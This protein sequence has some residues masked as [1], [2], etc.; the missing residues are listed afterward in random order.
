MAK[1][2][3]TIIHVN[4]IVIRN[5]KKTG[6][7]APVIAIKRGRKTE[8]AHEALIHGP[9]QVVYSPDKPLSCGARVWISTEAEVTAVTHSADVLPEKGQQCSAGTNAGSGTKAGRSRMGSSGL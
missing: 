3:K 6:A 9:A 8:Y 2:K 4:Q 5:N 7:R 1:K